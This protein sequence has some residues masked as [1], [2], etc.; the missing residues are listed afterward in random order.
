MAHH[1]GAVHALFPDST[2]DTDAEA[3]L[4]QAGL[5]LQLAEALARPETPLDHDT[6]REATAYVLERLRGH[7]ERGYRVLFECGA[8]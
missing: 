8:A 7:F 6:R 3:E 2:E 1:G 4:V 5:L